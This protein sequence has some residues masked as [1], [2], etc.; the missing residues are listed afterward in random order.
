MLIF[1]ILL[2]NRFYV[3][4]KLKTDLNEELKKLFQQ[5]VLDQHIEFILCKSFPLLVFYS[6][7]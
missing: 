7:F 5:H 4:T 1:F 2:Q 6:K 3:E